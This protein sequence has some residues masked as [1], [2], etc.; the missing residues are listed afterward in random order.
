M[1]L[2]KIRKGIIITIMIRSDIDLPRALKKW[3]IQ[4]N[5][6]SKATNFNVTA[7]IFLTNHLKG[8]LMQFSLVLF[9][10]LSVTKLSCI[11]TKEIPGIF[12]QF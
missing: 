5:L 6:S 8:S 3:H 1:K 11:R 2:F 4:L 9:K 7:I 10:T 12:W